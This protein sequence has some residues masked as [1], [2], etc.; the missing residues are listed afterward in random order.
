MKT[1]EV[2]DGSQRNIYFTIIEKGFN[3]ISKTPVL[4]EKLLIIIKRN[5]DGIKDVRQVSML[6][7]R[8][9]DNSLE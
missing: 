2:N 6:F 9:A 7:N 4:T 1:V 5:K 3:K 8:L